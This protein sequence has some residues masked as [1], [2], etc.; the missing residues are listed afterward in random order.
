[1]NTRQQA[2]GITVTLQ[3][4]PCQNNGAS[5]WYTT[6]LVGTPGQCLKLSLDTGTNITWITSSLCA[7]DRCQHYSGGRFDYQA[8]SSFAFTDCLQRPYSFGPWGTLQAELG[9]E[10]LTLNDTKLPTQLMLAADYTGAQFRQLDWDGGIGF[11]SSSAY[12]DASSSF[13]FQTLMNSGKIDPRQPFVTFDLNPSLRRGVCQMGAV[14]ASKTVGPRL[15]LPWALYNK[16]RG[17]E[18]IWST[19]LVSY[20]VGADV[21]A[22][23]VTF[24][25]D[26]GTSGFKGDD[27]LMRQTLERIARGGNPEVV[28]GFADGEITLGAD[29]YNVLIEEGPDQGKTLAQFEPLGLADLV[30]VGS[31]V[32][33]HCYTVYEYRVVQCRP[34][35]YSL[36]PVGVWLFNR[37]DGPQIISRSSSQRFDTQAR[38]LVSKKFVLSPTAATVETAPPLSVT[39][40]WKNGY[41]SV[42]TLTVAGNVV[43][44]AYQ[45]STGSTGRY[46]ITGYQSSTYPSQEKGLPV[47]LTIEWHALD[48]GPAD[49][50]WHWVS[51]LCGQL[52]RVTGE[53]RLKLSHLLVVTNDFPDLANQGT[54]LDKLSYRRVAAEAIAPCKVAPALVSEQ[55]NPLNGTWLAA[56]GHHLKLHVSASSQQA[57]GCVSGTL[58]TPTERVEVSGFTDI[59]AGAGGLTQQSVSLAALQKSGEAALTLAGSLDLKKDGLTLL[60]LFTSSTTVSQRYVQTQ[61]KSIMFRRTLGAGAH[62]IKPC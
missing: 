46:A 6:V 48:E 56:D 55:D 18:Y 10:V 37:P 47:A 34:G 53:D 62:Q 49:P 9:S 7:P 12:V 27:R 50:S 1:M 2:D 52:H 23:N 43:T 29:L 45:S 22:T 25:L 57:F 35:T 54:Y 4:G 26:S 41:G 17:V 15:F 30:L 20:T 13:V 19:P 33:E 38:T 44:G 11:P 5:P 39:G 31:L 60:A 58:T 3:R 28:L 42:M 8:S 16:V 21:L 36:A 14:D 32:M 59:N 51:G 40:T 24:A 61:I